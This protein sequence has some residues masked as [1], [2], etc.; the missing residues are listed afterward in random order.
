MKSESIKNQIWLKTKKKRN[1]TDYNV[2]NAIAS[3]AE[4]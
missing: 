4:F 3:I 1:K 2:T